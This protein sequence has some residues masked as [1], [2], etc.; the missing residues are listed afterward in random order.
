MGSIATDYAEVTVRYSLDPSTVVPEPDTGKYYSISTDQLGWHDARETCFAM[1]GD[2]VVINSELEQYYLEKLLDPTLNYWIGATDEATEGDWRW[3][4]GTKLWE[5]AGNG[6]IYGYSNWWSGQPDDYGGNEDYGGI[7]GGTNFHWNDFPSSWTADYICEFTDEFFTCGD[8]TIQEYEE[9]DDSNTDNTD[10]CIFCKNAVCSDS[11]LWDGVEECDDG[12]TDNTDAC[13]VCA[14]AECGD[15]FAWAGNEQCDD[16]TANSDTP[17]TACRT[18]CTPKRC[19]DGITD[20]GEECDDG[21][22]NSD[23]PDAA[24]RTDCTLKR[25]GDG[26]TDTGEGCDDRKN[27][28]NCDGCLDDCTAHANF[29]GDA[30]VCGDSEAC[31]DGNTVDGDGCENNCAYTSCGNSTVEAPEVCDGNTIACIELDPSTWVGGGTATC[32]TLCT[33]WDTTQCDDGGC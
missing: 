20:T 3:V 27:G 33:G 12:N 31:D 16:G 29:C 28:N 4:D 5:G 23:V 25:C 19:G 21:I 11:F 2:L 6:A 10:A 7:F 24:C 17:D 14:N 1:G 26:V 8:G 9:C 15:G 30:Y 22:A 32:N 18:D 13:A